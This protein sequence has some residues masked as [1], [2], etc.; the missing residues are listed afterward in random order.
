MPHAL[1]SAATQATFQDKLASFVDADGD[2]SRAIIEKIAAELDHVNETVALP[3]LRDTL[4][5]VKLAVNQA[6]SDDIETASNGVLASISFLWPGSW[7]RRS[8]WS[9]WAHRR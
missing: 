3:A 5:E 4:L 1:A 6:R 2:R 8:R 9:S 7:A